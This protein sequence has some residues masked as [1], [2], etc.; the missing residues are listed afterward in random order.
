MSHRALAAIAPSDLP[1]VFMG[2]V[3]SADRPDGAT[4]HDD[5][6]DELLDFVRH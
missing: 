4:G 6:R 1:R 3:P 2:A 5:M